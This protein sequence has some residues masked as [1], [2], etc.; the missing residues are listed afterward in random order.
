M[1]VLIGD[2]RRNG[3][4]VV[5]AVDSVDPSAVAESERVS[6]NQIA[7]RSRQALAVGLQAAGIVVIDSVTRYQ[8]KKHL[9]GGL[10]FVGFR[11]AFKIRF[12]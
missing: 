11:P 3:E 5:V 10:V 9:R 12:E 8:S 6:G 4:V 1:L 2:H 7:P